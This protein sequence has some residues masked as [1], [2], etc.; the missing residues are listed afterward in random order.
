MDKF[1]QEWITKKVQITTRALW[2]AFVLDIKDI[3]S[4]LA[5]LLRSGMFAREGGCYQMSYDIAEH[6]RD[7]WKD[8]L[9]AVFSR[10]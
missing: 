1:G 8:L 7:A 9:Y 2:E 5:E 6:S 3:S 4:G 10:N